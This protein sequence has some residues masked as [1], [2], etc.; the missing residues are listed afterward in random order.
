MRHDTLWEH[1]NERRHKSPAQTS[2]SIGI[3]L[4]VSL[5]MKDAISPVFLR[6]LECWITP[7]QTILCKV[8]AFTCKLSS[9]CITK[10]IHH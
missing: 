8:G 10:S 3:R 6:E 2:V 9:S 1:H 5:P 7:S 4:E